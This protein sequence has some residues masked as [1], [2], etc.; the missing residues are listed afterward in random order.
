MLKQTWQLCKDK[1]TTRT[2][3]WIHILTIFLIYV[4]LLPIILVENLQT[5]NDPTDNIRQQSRSRSIR[6]FLNRKYPLQGEV[7]FLNIRWTFWCSHNN[8][9][10]GLHGWCYADDILVILVWSW[11]G[12]GRLT[13]CRLLSL[14]KCLWQS[15]QIFATL[16]WSEYSWESGFQ[17]L[18]SSSHPSRTMRCKD[19]R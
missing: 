7:S 15:E 1:I 9:W 6:L 16:R 14:L 17:M 2:F 8:G 4:D 3:E 11:W 5:E 18:S 13:C 19:N 10:G 12:R